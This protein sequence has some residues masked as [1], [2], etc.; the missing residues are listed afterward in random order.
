MKPWELLD[1]VA[2]PGDG[3]EL[4][5]YRRDEEFSIRADRIELMN[6]RQH[7]S[8]EALAEMSCARIAHRPRARVLVGGLGMGY[9][10]AAALEHS[11]ADSQ[12]VVAEL[13]PAVVKWNRGPLAELAG[14]PIENERV[15]VREI[16]VVQILKAER[17]AF[18][19]ILLDVDNGPEGL[20]RTKNN[21]LYSREGLATAYAAL[22]P[23]S[24]LGVW[25]VTANTAFLRRLQETGFKV[26]Q[27][28]VRSRGPLRGSQH[29]IWIAQRGP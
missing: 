20:T 17:K 23:A 16:D 28:R 7:G 3:G 21:W 12:I 14:R 25:S 15:M 4:R 19:A 9:T 26:E 24:V 2:V 11:G 8:E 29:T 27:S 18:D 6:S 13:V 22:R 10:V 5:L 1:S